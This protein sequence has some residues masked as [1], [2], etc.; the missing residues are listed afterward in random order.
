[1]A[2]LHHPYS[3]GETAE[4]VARQKNISREEQDEF[5]LGSQQKY[6]KALKEGKWK[7]E[8]IGVEI[9]GGKDEKIFFE[10]DEHPRETSMEKLAG[11]KPAFSK[12]GSVTAGLS[13]GI[14]DGAAGCSLQV[15]PQ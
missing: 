1:M 15:N 4:N 9:L 11:L 5:A 7:D 10:K 3:M 6:F 13:S 8:I 14:N 12:D 2:E